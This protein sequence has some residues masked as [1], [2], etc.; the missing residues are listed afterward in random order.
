MT[1][2]LGK[3]FLK[4]YIAKT[5]GILDDYFQKK[6]AEAKGISEINEEIL[7]A[8]YETVKR[9]KRIRG[10]LIT[11]GYLLANNT[12]EA[13]VLFA[14]LSV[15]LF[16]AAVLVHDDIMDEDEIRRG[17]RTI[18]K[19]C[20]DIAI[21]DSIPNAPHYG[22]SQAINIADGGYFMAWEALLNSRLKNEDIVKS[23]EVFANFVIRVAHGQV[24]DVA[25]LSMKG[26]N[27][28][29]ISK[30]H[31]YKTAEYTGVMPLLMGAALAGLHDE[32]LKQAIYNYGLAFGW[33]FQI[34]DD[35]LGIFG[36]EEEFGKP[37]GSDLR[38]GKNTFLTL[39]VQTNGTDEQK[40]FLK[41]CLGNHSITKEDV[42]KMKAIFKEC[43]AY[44][45]AYSEGMKY[46]QEGIKYIPQITE[47]PET[48]EILESLI[49]YMMERVV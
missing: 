12:K 30:V 22:I 28:D 41:Y 3:K 37:I 43:G 40:E 5:E 25:N 21:R 32:E 31:R 9:G 10:A 19:Q 34:Q 20:E 7:K 23:G 1:G 38:E 46:V 48:K 15:E 18:H 42:E 47:K 13:E 35:I 14:S 16:H 36:E 33:A 26:A 29:H 24:L 27:P 49:V 4:D 44:D 17:L 11:L 39:H 6:I 45:Y 2:D 8:F